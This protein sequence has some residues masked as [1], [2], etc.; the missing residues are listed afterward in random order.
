MQQSA[1]VLLILLNRVTATCKEVAYCAFFLE[2]AATVS[3]RILFQSVFLGHGLG[4]ARWGLMLGFFTGIGIVMGL[5]SDAR[6]PHTVQPMSWALDA[7]ANVTLGVLPHLV[8]S[9]RV[10]VPVFRAQKSLKISQSAVF[11]LLVST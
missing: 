8:W 6:Y 1:A 10:G 9:K 11:L 5:W 7:K 3:S 4:F 2:K